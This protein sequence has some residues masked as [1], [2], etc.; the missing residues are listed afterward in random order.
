MGDLRPISYRGRCL[1][2]FVWPAD[3]IL[4]RAIIGWGPPTMGGG[5]DFWNPQEK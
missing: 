5:L 3:D 1:L 2:R 4:A